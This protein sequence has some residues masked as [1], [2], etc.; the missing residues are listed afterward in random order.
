MLNLELE[1][2]LGT[3]RSCTLRLPALIGRDPACDVVLPSWRIARQHA[4]LLNRAGAVYIQDH[5]SLTGVQLNG[6]RVYDDGPLRVGDVLTAGGF[7]LR[8]AGLGSPPRPGSAPPM[9]EPE[10]RVSAMAVAT[11]ASIPVSVSAPSKADQTSAKEQIEHVQG[12]GAPLLSNSEL[13]RQEQQR[14]HQAL[15][16]ALDLERRDLSRVTD[17]QL[18][19]EAFDCLGRLIQTQCALPPHEQARLQAS[20]CAEAVGLGPLESLLADPAVSEIMVNRYDRV[21]VEKAGRLQAH[22]MVFSSDA[23]LRAVIDRI[24]APLGRRLDISSP[25]V[26]GRLADGSRFHAVLSPIAV[27]GTCVTIRKFPKRRLGL[28]DLLQMGSLSSE[29]GAFLRQAVQR[30]C[31]ILVSG[32]TGTGKTTLLNVL[33]TCIDEGERLVTLEDAAELQLQHSNWVALEAR[34]ANAEGQGQ[35][36][37]RSLL[38]QALRMRPDRIVVGECRGAEAFDMLSAMNTGHEGSMGT[39]HANT[40]RDALSRL[41]GMVLMAGLDLPLQVVR[42][43]IARALHIIVQLSRLPDGRRLV[44]EIVELTGIEAQRIQLQTLY[45]YRPEL[46]FAASGLRSEH[47]FQSGEQA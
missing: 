9:T 17:K 25:A 37:I 38:R 19:Q 2:E 21:F 39:L 42:E 14:L 11:A 47:L 7:K 32:G 26:D 4:S 1:S 24:L 22:P 46:G 15:L 40:P 33:S 30:R 10:T 44:H 43:H 16:S 12:Q 41:E 23:A 5:G 3:T 36:D 8:I 13:F 31:N 20:V 35:V 45:C 27:K 28:E 29:M 18:E 34:P 6:K